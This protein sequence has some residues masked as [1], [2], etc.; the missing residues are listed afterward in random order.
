MCIE[1]CV[2]AASISANTAKQKKKKAGW[3]ERQ[4]IRFA[5]LL[6]S[7]QPAFLLRA[8]AAQIQTSMYILFYVT[9]AQSTTSY[10]APS[11]FSI[12]NR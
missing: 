9:T 6:I 2:L 10:S 12:W 1:V 7:T 11:Y 5:V 4:G 8:Y 3:L